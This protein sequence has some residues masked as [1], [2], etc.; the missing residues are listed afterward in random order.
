MTPTAFHF[1]VVL[2]ISASAV[3]P[4]IPAPVMAAVAGVPSVLG[5][6]YAAW[7]VRRMARSTVLVAHLVDYVIYGAFPAAAYLCL[8][9]SVVGLWFG[10]PFALHGVAIG[11]LALLLVGIRNAW[12]LAVYL[13]YH[14]DGA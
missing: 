7:V 4:G 11:A 10:A 12:D 8:L 14:K 6:L 3:M 13:A 2:F 1:G 5:L 9:V